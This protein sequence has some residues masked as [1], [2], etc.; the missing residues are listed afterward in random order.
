[1]A[2]SARL[3]VGPGFPLQPPVVFAVMSSNAWQLYDFAQP[4]VSCPR[5]RKPGFSRPPVA[6]CSVRRR[7]CR[8]HDHDAAEDSSDALPG[9]ECR[10]PGQLVL[11]PGTWRRPYPVPPCP[12]LIAMP[13]A[14]DTPTEQARTDTARPPRSAQRALACSRSSAAARRTGSSLVTLIPSARPQPARPRH[15]W[16]RPVDRGARMP[17]IARCQPRRGRGSRD[18]ASAASSPR[19]PRAGPAPCASAPLR[20]KA[21]S[22]Q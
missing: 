12:V 10:Q 20:G 22:Q 13:L 11:G 17:A 8:R 7:R 6:T 4:V 16:W 3:S 5:E 9:E 1:M 18:A 2:R 14:R 21:A 19:R 15:Q